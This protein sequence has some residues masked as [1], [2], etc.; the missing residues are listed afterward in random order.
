V[1]LI[2]RFLLIHS[3][4]NETVITCDLNVEPSDIQNGGKIIQA[5][6]CW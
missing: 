4:D 3:F 2:F 6:K 5:T 1:I